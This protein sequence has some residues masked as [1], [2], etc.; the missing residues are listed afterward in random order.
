MGGVSWELVN[1]AAGEAGRDPGELEAL[2]LAPVEEAPHHAR[3]GAA[4]VGIGDPGGEELI[5]GKQRIGGRRA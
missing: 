1:E 5:G 3:I 4:G 2:I